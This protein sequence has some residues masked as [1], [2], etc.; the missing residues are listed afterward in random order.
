MEVYK[1]KREHLKQAIAHIEELENSLKQLKCAYTP[2]IEFLQIQLKGKKDSVCIKIDSEE[3]CYIISDV[4][5]RFLEEYIEVLEKQINSS[6]K[7]LV[8]K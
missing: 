5:R 1:K 2:S 4:L 7:M 8:K 3:Q 6:M